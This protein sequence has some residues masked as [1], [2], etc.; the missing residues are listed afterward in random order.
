MALLL[1]HGAD[2]DG[3]DAFGSTALGVAARVGFAAG[4]ALLLANGAGPEVVGYEGRTALLEAVEEGNESIVLRLLASGAAVGATDKRGRGALAY[5]AAEHKVG[6]TASLAQAL[7]DH[8]AACSQVDGF[9][10]TPLMHAARG[11]H[12]EV[13]AA[14][15]AGG[16]G[17]NEHG[18]ASRLEQMPC[19]G[20]QTPLLWA[21]QAYRRAGPMVRLLLAAGASVRVRGHGGAG[22]LVIAA[23]F[24]DTEVLSLLLDAG[25]AVA[26]TNASGQTALH[27]AAENG[28]LEAVRLLLTRGAPLEA[29]DD[30]FTPLMT[31]LAYRREPCA[32]ALVDS[33]AN[34]NAVTEGVDWLAD[35][36]VLML[37][38]GA[39]DDLLFERNAT[40]HVDLGL[41]GK[42]LARGANVNAVT[43][44]GMTPLINGLYCVPAVEAARMLLAAGAGV[45]MRT[46][47][48]TTALH[49]A[50]GLR[51]P[52][53][54]AL[55]LA[56]GAE[57]TA[58]DCRGRTPLEVAREASKG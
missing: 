47:D 21:A 6:R 50:A 56:H 40:R 25:C 20:D 7:L 18:T 29:R 51:D 22:P 30:L 27:Q 57:E 32:E 23:Q 49:R 24:G 15:L 54:Y 34:V 10:M 38:L 3:V 11:G 17:A 19:G 46:A 42:L 16:A 8:G 48:G 44:F 58:R 12:V 31:A 13:A 55:L 53:L 37:A 4:V 28:H 14:L 5:A 36:S 1:Q 26:D 2:P 33:G 39:L 41:L 35:T 9:G 45:N 43:R 52:E